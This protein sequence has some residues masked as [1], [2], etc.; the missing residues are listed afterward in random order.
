MDPPVRI[1]NRHKPTKVGLRRIKTNV[2]ESSYLAGELDDFSPCQDTYSLFPKSLYLVAAVESSTSGYLR[3]EV[4]RLCR[5][6]IGSVTL[7]LWGP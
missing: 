2:L 4:S 7:G 5:R 1:Q 3:V 6:L